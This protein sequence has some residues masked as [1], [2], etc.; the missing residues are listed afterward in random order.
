[1]HFGRMVLELTGRRT[2]REVWPHLALTTLGGVHPAP[3][4]PGLNRLILGTDD[5]AGS[6][7][8]HVEVYNATEGFFAL[9]RGDDADLTLLPDAGIFYEFVRR[10]D[11]AAGR[12]DCAVTLPEVELGVEYAPVLTSMNGLWRYLVGD[13]VRFTATRPYRLVVS[14]RVQQFLNLAGEELIVANT[15][16]ALAALCAQHGLTLADYTVSALKVDVAGNAAAENAFHL[17][18]VELAQPPSWSDGEFARRLDATL[19]AGHYD[20]AKVRQAGQWTGAGFGLGPPAV[21]LLAPGSFH[22][23]LRSRYGPGLG[24]QSK[25]PRLSADPAVAAALLAAVDPPRLGAWMDGLPAA[26]H[27]AMRRLLGTAG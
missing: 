18:L 26:Y 10:P 20:Y 5:A 2:L 14:G 16:A 25:A 6:G 9:Q 17:W 11:A 1:M 7:L 4:L 12:F 13:T 22:A 3:Y 24:P 15:D 23:W 27:G 8:R 19:Q 21:L